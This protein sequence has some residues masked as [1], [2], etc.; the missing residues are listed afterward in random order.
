MEDRYLFETKDN[1]SL[2]LFSPEQNAI[3]FTRKRENRPHNSGAECGV[4]SER[5]LLS[6]P[7]LF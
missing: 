7:S 1:N 4:R 5:K 2:Y 3:I 6:P